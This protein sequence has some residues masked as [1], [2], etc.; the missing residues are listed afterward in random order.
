MNNKYH[1][2]TNGLFYALVGGIISYLLFMFI[3]EF[4]GGRNVEGAIL[5]GT[6]TLSIVICFCTGKLLD[7]LNR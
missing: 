5:A 7:R 3:F 2:D 4:L 6:V 1:K